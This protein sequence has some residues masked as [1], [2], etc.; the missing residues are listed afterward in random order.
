MS[1]AGEPSGIEFDT[2]A[3]DRF[4]RRSVPG[5]TGRMRIE[6]V[7][8]GQSNPTFFVSYDQARLVLRKQPPGAL[9]PSAHAVDREYRVITALAGTA[10]PV[11]PSLLFC[12]DR[13]IVGT[14]FYVMQRL[15]GRIFHDCSLP[16]VQAEQRGPMYQSVATTLAALHAVDPTSVGLAD[17]G[18]P[19][20]YFARQIARWGRQW[21]S[22]RTGEN[23]DVEYLRVW[24]AANLPAEEAN[25]IAHGDYRLGNVMFHPTEPRVIAVLDWELSTLGHPLADLAH[26]AIAWHARPEEYGGLAGIDLAGAGLPDQ[27]AFETAYDS[28]AT[29]G[30]RLST[31]HMVFAL[32]RFAV[33]FEGIA[34][35]AKQGNAASADAAEKGRLCAVFA[36]RARELLL[37]T[38]WT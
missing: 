37:R 24:L 34:A 17:F 19:E 35:R 30:L 12:A 4:L 25:A 10:V 23:D 38:V 26:C 33:I 27:A 3:V 31:F 9:L 20:G 13:G 18:R 29:H 11:P 6:R 22:A 32:F 16:G 2:R 36:R 8:G 28:A 14:P 1:E 15:D 5:T 21:E 7:S